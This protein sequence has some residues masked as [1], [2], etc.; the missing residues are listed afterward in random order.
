VSARPDL[1]GKRRVYALSLG[2]DFFF[3]KCQVFSFSLA[4]DFEDNKAFSP[5]DFS[6]LLVIHFVPRVSFRALSYSTVQSLRNRC[7][8]YHS[9]ICIIHPSIHPSIRSRQPPYPHPKNPRLES[10]AIASTPP[11]PRPRAPLRSQRIRERLPF[12]DR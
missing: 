10:N 4:C 3:Q 2:S 8:T 11:T 5:L 9:S 1:M 12:P 6:F 7:S